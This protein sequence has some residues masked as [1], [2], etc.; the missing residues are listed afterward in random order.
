MGLDISLQTR[1]GEPAAAADAALARHRRPATTP[2]AAGIWRAGADLAGLLEAGVR[3]DRSALRQALERAFGAGDASGAWDWKDAYEA[4]ETAAVLPLVKYGRAI[5]LHAGDPRAALRRIERIARLEPP[6]TRR[7]ERQVRL[8][9]FSTPLAVAWVAAVAAG[10]RPGDVVLE[11]SAGTGTLAAMALPA[12]DPAAGGRLV[13]NELA[14]DRAGLLARTFADQPV[15]R[16]DAA[17]IRDRLPEVRPSAV[18]MN[19]PFSRTI[20]DTGPPFN[21]IDIAPPDLRQGI[22]DRQ[23]GGM[24][25]HLVHEYSDRMRH[26]VVKG[27]NKVTIELDLKPAPADGGDAEEE[28]P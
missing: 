13:L 10:L 12:L 7:N 25:L 6:Q 27:H 24:G 23:L 11:P 16:H 3:L 9:Q 5:G 22:D 2:K 19:P 20:L 8:Q 15:T 4:A 17:Q 1:S 26:E 21:P 28:Q 18:I 14:A